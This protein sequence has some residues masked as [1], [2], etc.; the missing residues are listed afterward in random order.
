MSAHD[1]IGRLDKAMK[2]LLAQWQEAHA[3]WNDP[4]A[5]RF[6]QDRLLP[7]QMDLKRAIS[8]MEQIGKVMAAV[9]RDCDEQIR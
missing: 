5:A 7:L 6:E 8:A 4:V 3:L 2:T 9:S 1:S